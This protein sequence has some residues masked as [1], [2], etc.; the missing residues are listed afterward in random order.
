MNNLIGVSSSGSQLDVRPA[1]KGAI[2]YKAMTFH[3]SSTDIPVFRDI[4]KHV[5]NGPGK[6]QTRSA[7]DVKEIY[8][9]R[10]VFNAALVAEAIRNAQELTGKKAITGEDMRKGLETLELTPTRI[11]KAGFE[12]F[13]DSMK[14][15]CLDHAG[16]NRMFVQ[17]WDGEN[18]Q[19]VSD[20]I[21]PMKDVVRPMLESAA[22][23]YVSG[24]KHW[25][26]QKCN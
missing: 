2:G 17:R 13:M 25:Q 26:T 5:I 19:K 20:W 1:G 16:A 10:G 3:G 15:T 11:K 23:K 18:W 6:T 22:A 14:I 21:S 7:K 12:G 24:K 9:M 8:Y 4:I